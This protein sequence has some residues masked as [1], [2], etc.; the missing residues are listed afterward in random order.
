[1]M[2]KQDYFPTHGEVIRVQRN[3]S[4]LVECKNG[5]VVTATIAARFRTPSG[6]R[7]SKNGV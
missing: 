6:K 1:M 2:N 7:K 5:K 4:F 3:K